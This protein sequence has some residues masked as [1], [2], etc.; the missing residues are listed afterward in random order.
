MNR[1]ILFGASALAMFAAAAAQAG[2]KQKV[3]K[4]AAA[5]TAIKAEMVT[6][7]D[8]AKAYAKAEFAKADANGDKKVEKAEFLA[9][10]EAAHA[11]AQALNDTAEA[12]PAAEATVIAEG[13]TVE[14]AEQQFVGLSKGDGVLAIEE[15]IEARLADFAQA[16]A[17]QNG[18]LD[19]EEKE[20]FAALVKPGPV[21]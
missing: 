17:D 5:E 15:L 20:A 8:D 4:Q 16:D 6:T 19:G 14:T 7:P 1:A 11:A 13:D 2:E 10:A 21:L 12:A 3:D 9:F 18:A